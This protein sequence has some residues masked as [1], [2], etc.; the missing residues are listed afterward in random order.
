[1]TQTCLFLF[2]KF[3]VAEEHGK[4]KAAYYAGWAAG[5]QQN[6][7]KNIALSIWHIHKYVSPYFFNKI[8]Y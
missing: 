3:Q 4:Q 2:K 1:M 7:G 5:F 6:R 8:F